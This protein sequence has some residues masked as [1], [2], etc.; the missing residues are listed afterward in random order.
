MLEDMMR[1]PADEVIVAVQ[2][3]ANRTFCFLRSLITL[4]IKPDVLR[5]GS[6]LSL[7]DLHEP[8]RRRC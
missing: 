8:L 6:V 5:Y 7:T 4:T 3:Q 1:C 2:I